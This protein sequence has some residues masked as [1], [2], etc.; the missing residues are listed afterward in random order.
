[1]SFM[2]HIHIPHLPHGDPWHRHEINKNMRGGPGNRRAGF[3][4]MNNTEL[5]IVLGVL[6]VFAI[7]ILVVVVI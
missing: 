7:G 3:G 6:A 1:M 2:G 5:R 4:S